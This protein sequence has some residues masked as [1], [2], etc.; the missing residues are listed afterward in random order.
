M[1]VRSIRKELKD[2]TILKCLDGIEIECVKTMKYLS[3]IIDDRLRFQDHCDYMLKKIGKK[4]S[5]LNRVGNYISICTRC[6]IYKIIIAPHF[7]YC[8]TLLISM[9]ETQII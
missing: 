8:A 6:T 5:F 4:T 2:N 7:E 3:M 9:G 1:I